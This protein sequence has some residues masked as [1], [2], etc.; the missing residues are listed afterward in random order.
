[1]AGNT[2]VFVKGLPPSLT[3]EEFRKNFSRQAPITDSKLIPHRRIGYVGYRTAEDAERAVKYHNRSYIRMSKISVEYARSVEDQQARNLHHDQNVAPAISGRSR[4]TGQEKIAGD[5]QLKRK[6]EDETFDAG[7]DRLQEFLQVMQRPSTSK[8][9]ENQDRH[10]SMPVKKVPLAQAEEFKEAENAAEPIHNE[11]VYSQSESGP[12]SQPKTPPIQAVT[13]QKDARI[14]T[15]G[16][17][18]EIRPQDLSMAVP[19]TS[20][21]DWLRSRTSRLLGLV[22]DEDSDLELNRP[23]NLSEDLQSTVAQREA[24][25]TEMIPP[26][27]G[28]KADGNVN[29]IDGEEFEGDTTTIEERNLHNGRLF[30][31]NLSYSATESDLRDYVEGNGYGELQE[32]RQSLHHFSTA[33]DILIE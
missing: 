28:I 18:S 8:T 10:L 19:T 1:M 24:I 16:H 33:P 12:T 17:S 4:I 29:T 11:K 23:K 25:S 15:E 22:A 2:R 30:L 9:W 3:V 14:E 27:L 20:D 26:D 32:V 6:R 13:V 5:P 21:E 7:A 31:R